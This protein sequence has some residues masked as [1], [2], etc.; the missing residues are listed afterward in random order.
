MRAPLLLLLL[1]AGCVRDDDPAKDDG[2]DTSSPDTD[3]AD[4]D[5]ADTDTDTADTDTADTDTA[6]TDTAD[7]DTADTDIA[8]TDTGF[9]DTDT[10]TGSTAGGDTGPGPDPDVDEPVAQPKWQRMWGATDERVRLD[11]R[12]SY[13]PSG[14]AITY[15]WTASAGTLDDPTSATP[16]YTGPSGTVTLVVSSS[17]QASDPVTM[18]VLADDAGARIPTDY[19]TVEDALFAGETILFLAAGT[20]GPIVGADAVIGDP[21]GGVVIDAAGAPIAVD[22]VSYLRH[23]TITGAAEHGV[24]A[25]RDVR[26][27]DCVIEGNGTADIDGGGLWSN[28]TVVLFDS[29]VQGNLGYLGGGIYLERNASV[30]A[31]QAVIADNDAAYGGGIYT[32]TT[33]GNV[34][35]QNSLLVGNA[36]SVNGGGGVFLDSRAFLTRVTVADNAN[37][38]VRLR[39]GYFE[40]E[41]TVFASNG[42]YGIDE[43]DAP[44]VKVTN[45]V[46]GTSDI[47]TGGDTPTTAD[48]NLFGDPSFADFTSGDAWT[49]QDFRILTGSFGSDMLA[50]QD[51]DGTAQDAG[52]YGGFLGRF[53]SGVQGVW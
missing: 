21:D 45:S 19:A 15:A 29:V 28:S 34:E 52:G 8:D 41:E 35:L 53:P 50:G 6:D 5:T 49:D 24:Y 10:D 51:R 27:H 12:G 25:D 44:T 14:A 36:A 39:Y 2:D 7:T 37:G 18:N 4:T 13:D 9:V 23:L 16:W 1:A 17:R 3:T 31:Q 42:V 47:V 48:G 32:N 33:F 38:G 40:V 26:I 46:F 20:Y 30:Y 11:G 22:G 43:A